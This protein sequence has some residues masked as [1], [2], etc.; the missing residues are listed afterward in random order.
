MYIICRNFKVLAIAIIIANPGIV[1]K[2][3][4]VNSKWNKGKQRK[5]QTLLLVYHNGESIAGLKTTN[6]RLPIVNSPLRM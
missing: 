2:H 3:F 5:N 4:P 1:T 6:E